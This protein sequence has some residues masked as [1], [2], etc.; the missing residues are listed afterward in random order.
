L[1]LLDHPVR[2]DD[3]PQ[4]EK[5][6]EKVSFYQ[7]IRPIFQANCHGC[8]QPARSKGK[9][10][11]TK[12]DQ[13]IA[14]GGDEAAIIPHQPTESLL[15]DLITP[16][17][18]E[19]EMPEKGDPLQPEQ[20]EL[21][22]RWIAEGAV[23][24]T[25][26]AAIEKF[27][28]DHPPL[29]ESPPMVTALDYSPD[30][31]WLAVSGYHEVLIHD[32]EKKGIVERLIGMSERIESIAFSP[33]GKKLAVTG[34]LPGRMGELQI[35]DT[36]SWKLALSVPVTFDTIYGASWSPDNRL[37][38]FGC[39][40][41]T[42]RAIDITTGEQVLFNGVSSDWI[43]DTVF[44]KDGN[45]VISV[46]RDMTA[47]LTEL[48]TQRF[49][50]NITSITPAILKG[51]LAAVD[52]HPAKEE[53]LVGG[54]RGTPQIYRIHREVKRVIGDNSNLLRSFDSMPGR[55]F[56]IEYNAD[57]KR[58]AAGSSLD[59]KGHLSIY[60][61]EF[62]GTLPAGMKG[63]LEKVSTSRNAAEKKKIEEFHSK[64]IETLATVEFDSPV[65][66]LS[67][68]PQRSQIAVG[69]ADGLIRFV[70]GENGN[71][72]R[73]ALSVPM[74][75]K[76][77]TKLVALVA[78]P[79]AIEIDEK[80]GYQQ[81]LVTGLQSN[82]RSVDL[83]HSASYNL[84][85]EIAT[86]EGGLIR[87]KRDG[88]TTLS[89]THQG[90]SIDVSVR[91]SGR[92]DDF[93]P[94]FLRDVNPVISKSG[95]N[96]GTC[97]G[98]KEGKNGFKLSLRGY[99]PLFDVRAFSDDHAG[100]RIN[101]A[102]AGDSLMLLKATAAVPHEGGQRFHAD[103][104]YYQILR[105]WIA[106]G[107]QLDVEVPRVSK[108]ELAPTQ[109]VVHDIGGQQQMR[110]TAHYD[111]GSTRDVTAEAFISSGD[112]EVASC[113]ETGRVTTLRRG[114]APLLARFEGAYVATTMTVMGDRSGFEWEAPPQGSPIDS[115]VVDKWKRMQ[116]RGSDLC[117][118]EEFVRRIHLD[119]T[120]LPP[121]IE[122]ISEFMEDS[123]PSM[124][125]RDA[126][127]DELIGSDSYV[128]HWGNRWADL[129]QVNSK[130]LGKEGAEG[131][132][133]WIHEEVEENTPYDQ[134]VWKILTASGSNKE[135]PPASYHKILRTPTEL[136]ENTT[137]LFLAIRFNCNKCHDHPFER[138][139]QDQYY[140]LAAYYGQVEL[141]KD[142]ASGDKRI[143]GTAVEGSKPLYE[144][145]SDGESGEVVHERTGA[146]TVPEFPYEAQFTAT[147]GA[148]RREQ[149][150]RWITS[151][152]NHYFARSY[153][154]RV[155]GYLT[156]LGLIDPL[157]DIRAGNPA[158]NPQ[159]LDHLTG[160][161]IESEFDVQRLISE[162]CKSRTYQLSIATNQ[163]NQGDQL[164]Y[165]HAI[166]RRLPAEVLF[167]SIHKVLGSTTRIP[168]V[169][170]G[171]RAAALP[172]V[173]IQ[174][175]DGFLTTLGRASRESS[176]ECDRTES[177]G[178]DSVM[179]LVTGPTVDQAI[180]DD[181]NAIRALVDE[182]PDDGKLIEEL[183]LRILNR[184]AT[185]KEVASL[186]AMFTEIDTDHASLVE[187]YTHY[188]QVAATLRQEKEEV[189]QADIADARAE[190]AAYTEEIAPREEELDKKRDEAIALASAEQIAYGK[191]I[192]E[193]L[194]TWEE[195]KKG[196]T[197]WVPLQLENLI[198][199][200]GATLTIEDDGA[201]FVSGKN[202]MGT[203]TFTA[204][205]DLEGVT[206]IR[207]GALADD[208]LPGRGP[209]R[210]ENG[211]Y[212]LSELELMWT[213]AP[214]GEVESESKKIALHNA[215]ANFSQTNYEISKAIDGKVTNDGWASS[216]QLGVDR[217]A[218]FEL[219]EVI[220][221]AGSVLSFTMH[222]KYD[223]GHTI[224]R[225]KVWVTTS[226]VPVT[227][228]LPDEIAAI[229]A[230]PEGS[231][232]DEQKVQLRNYFESNDPKAIEYKKK[233]ETA[234][235]PRPVDPGLLKF[236]E[237]LSRVEM[238]LPPDPELV[239]LERAMQLSEQQLKSRR[240]TLVQ[241]IAWALINNPAFL[242]NR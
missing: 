198:A 70:D 150:A 220:G 98:S 97:H 218:T 43:L 144:I 96:G 115:L 16:V 54:S 5:A 133:N 236:Q 140:Q 19:A 49:I 18:G 176:C 103:S 157:D 53:V 71:L 175:K 91:V 73:V 51:G 116:L 63:I 206:A 101:L 75:A 191:T 13:L 240:V 80:Y 225:F 110:V 177:L 28:V 9:Y 242:F 132:R 145:V 179:A 205:V 148:T 146:E 235:M 174:L 215:R 159:L 238:K 163:W 57:G 121:D 35:W 58:I 78:D 232:S 130:Y 184:P 29:Y 36:D 4:G 166:P 106:S 111:D 188:Q 66:S 107:C 33:D 76:G 181:K 112:T 186:K 164:N 224:G 65:Y 127:I 196:E 208:R 169:A 20:I 221:G 204:P 239:R 1:L 227:M 67:W 207:L 40:D 120:G 84:S 217:I 187:E 89:V 30:G 182:Q 52:R 171:T 123:R 81:I 117:T 93:R 128:V 234:K 119:L 141:K 213:P 124:I 104:D 61:S 2:G 162:I 158:T 23:D 202:G 137:Q 55:I 241:D 60:S 155:W 160:G 237:K 138:W 59:G 41:N 222:Y 37:V 229:V 105:D 228:G 192:P 102:Q 44:S 3:G 203:Y 122:G 151:P 82:G 212:V 170:E 178:L 190:V 87:P 125:K 154:N 32:V 189:Q 31:R 38:S 86:I 219:K 47:K 199:S 42:L 17:D 8:H 7:Q 72:L 126:L 27:D 183:Y 48:K 79:P 21:I 77:K 197:R 230:V 46:G 142:P 88:T 45:Y 193:K 92:N 180:S 113:D 201:V 172:D 118:D 231:R 25:P 6:P 34:G 22:A 99:D 165:S 173:G 226:Q 134:F 161:F 62:D 56:G 135:N 210:N 26:A 108:I 216:P 14:G 114:E 233:L 211:N 156:G 11:M 95:C 147:E 168:G 64:D 15:I 209:G 194:L 50:D 185:E 85:D 136:M 214:I 223:A 109:P 139:T 149:L 74:P 100:R 83:T 131:F 129:L 69:S 90:Q 143:G 10:V 39:G 152:D 24:D 195:Q 12:F 68:H 200:S 167:D 153:V 94:S